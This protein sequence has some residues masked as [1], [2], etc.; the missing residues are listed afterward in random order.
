MHFPQHGDPATTIGA[1]GRFLAFYGC[2]DLDCIYAWVGVKP[3]YLLQEFICGTANEL[4]SIAEHSCRVQLCENCLKWM[5]R[6]PPPAPPVED[7]S[8]WQP[9]SM[10]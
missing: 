5:V 1:L 9:D 10:Q 7:G 6:P 8:W 4:S 2:A 3:E